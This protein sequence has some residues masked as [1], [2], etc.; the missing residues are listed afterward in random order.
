MKSSEKTWDD[1]TKITGIGEARQRWLRESFDIHTF[2]DLANLSIAQIKEKMKADGLIISRKA[3]EAWLAQARELAKIASEPVNPSTESPTAGSAPMPR[4]DGWKPFAS[5]VVEYQSREIDSQG[6]EYRTVAHYMEEDVGK[7][8]PAIEGSQLGQWMIGSIRDKVTLP[9]EEFE[10]PQAQPTKASPD[11]KRNAAVK[12]TQVRILQPSNSA[13]PL[14]LIVPGSPFEF[15]VLQE[16]PFTFEIN[17]DL[18]GLAAEDVARKK[19]GWRIECKANDPV[20]GK[21][22][23][24]CDSGPNSLEEGQYKYKIVL[25]EISL[26]QG[27]YRVWVI[28]N[29]DDS[30][31]VLPDF[32]QIANFNSLPLMS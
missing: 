1:L 14:Q 10:L 7:E 27:S 19:I 32:L 20:S 12:I 13:T 3:I 15:S 2:H 16:K 23:Q 11:G 5:F 4:E 29:T 26:Q 22:S 18:T 21:F 6:M 25:P 17:F 24:L 31:L 28:L 30:E 8:W 9:E